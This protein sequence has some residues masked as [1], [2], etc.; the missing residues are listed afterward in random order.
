MQKRNVEHLTAHERV[1][2]LQNP[3][4]GDGNGVDGAG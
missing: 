2:K 4:H 1:F 3:S